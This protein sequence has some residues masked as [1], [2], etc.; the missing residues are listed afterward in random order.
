MLH[1]IKKIFTITARFLVVFVCVKANYLFFSKLSFFSTR[2][3]T[4][5]HC[6][7]TKLI[8]IQNLS[9]PLG[10]INAFSQSQS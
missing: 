2:F 3:I 5:M 1:T 6:K 8:I 4:K 7:F 10:I 9:I